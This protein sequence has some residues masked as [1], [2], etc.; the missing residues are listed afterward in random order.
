MACRRWAV[1]AVVVL[2]A[3]VPLVFVPVLR[4]ARFADPVVTSARRPA[5]WVQHVLLPIDGWTVCL[6]AGVTLWAVC[7]DQFPRPTSARPP[8]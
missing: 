5:F 6:L 3:F 2:A 7:R 4:L 1:P 8:A